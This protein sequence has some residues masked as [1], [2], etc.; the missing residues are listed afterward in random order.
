VSVD[1]TNRSSAASS[2]PRLSL[3][4]ITKAFGDALVLKGVDLDIAKGEVHGLVGQNGAGK[5]TLIKALAGSYPDYHGEVFIDG[6]PAH[7]SSPRQ[8]LDHGVAVVYQ[9]FSLVP[10]MTVAENILLG[11]EPG[12]VRYSAR[13]ITRAAQRLLAEVGMEGD[14]PLNSRVSML[15]AATQQRVEIAKVLTRQAKVLV[16]DEPT[17]RLA[18]PDRERLFELMRRIAATGTSVLFISHFLGEVLSLASRLTVLRDGSVVASGG[19]TEFDATSL[20]SALMGRTLTQ[21]TAA[22]IAAPPSATDR[23]VV[24]SVRALDCGR[25]TRDITFDLRGGEVVGL[26]GLVGS[27]RS[28]L[29]LSLV[30]ATPRLAGTV[31]LKGQLVHPKNPRQA[32]KQGI[33]M[34]PEDRRAQGLVAVLPANENLMLTSLARSRSRLGLVSP[35]HL[36]RV[37]KKAISDFEVRPAHGGR[38]AGTFSGGNQQKLL[39]AR[40]VL[41]EPDVLIVDQPSAGVDVGT[42]AQIH[43]L[44]R[45]L[46]DTGKAVL[47]ISDDIEEIIALSDRILTMRNGRIVVESARGSVDPDQLLSLIATGTS[48]G[49]SA[50]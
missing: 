44:L 12:T 32:L 20:T 24:L 26:A 16:L 9:E 14:L 33:T 27:G 46:A 7:L 6:E 35:A 18:G 8:A 31:T 50:K 30:G 49:T 5:S 29:A 45:E 47:V 13:A 19:V 42:K 22:E 2:V 28:A 34:V 4:G 15:S 43:K 40:S 11:A 25:Q 3:R 41:A 17:A 37:A 10:Q 21:L 39:L 36:R 38:P 48:P 1:T 23:D